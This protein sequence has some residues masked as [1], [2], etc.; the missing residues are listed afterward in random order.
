MIDEIRTPGAHLA[1]AAVKGQLLNQEP[2]GG[3]NQGG[4]HHGSSINET[5]SGG[6]RPFWASDQ[7]PTYSD[8]CTGYLDGIRCFAF[9][10]EI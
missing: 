6:R 7:K 9:G 4:I 10:L 8:L 3:K 1:G 2:G 5:A